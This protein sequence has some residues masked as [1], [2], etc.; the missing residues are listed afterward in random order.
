MGSSLTTSGV[1]RIHPL[2]TNW[3]LPIKRTTPS[4]QAKDIMRLTIRLK[5]L[6]AFAGVLALMALLGWTAV[7]RTSEMNADMQVFG[8]QTLPAA[9]AVGELKNQTGKFRRDQLRYATAPD[10]EARTGVAEDLTGDVD[11]VAGIVSTFEAKYLTSDQLRAALTAFNAGWEDYR[12]KSAELQPLTDAGRNAD[13]L[14]VINDG[15][16]DEAWDALKA[17][18]AALDEAGTAYA[19]EHVDEVAAD[20]AGA[21]RWTLTLLGLAIAMTALVAWLLTRS[22]SGGINRLLH[23]ARG[24]ADGDVDQNVTI[25]SKDE[26]GDAGREFERMIAYLQ[27]AAATADRI[28]DGDL[29]QP[30]TPHGEHDALGHALRRM[31]DNLRQTLGAVAGSATTVAS[32]S[33]QMAATSDETGRAVGEIAGAIANIAAGAERQVHSVERRARDDRRGRRR[34]GESAAAAQETAAAVNDAAA[35]AQEGVGA[36]EQATAAMHAVRESAT[37]AA[38]AIR[39]LG[40]KSEQIGGIVDTITGIAE[41]TNLLALNAAIEAARAGEQGRGFAVVAEEVRKL[42]EES[43]A[44]GGHDLRRSIE[45][46]QGETRTVVGVVEQASARTED[47]AATVEQAREAFLAIGHAVDGMTAR[48]DAIVGVADRIAADANAMEQGIGEV[49]LLAAGL[50]PRPSRSRRPPSRPRPRR[51]RSP[52]QRQSLS[53]TAKELEQIVGRFTL[54]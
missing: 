28:A 40:A 6:S 3:F 46:M 53:D 16:G 36:A 38:V 29:T 10:A 42:A 17:Q 31:S 18:I 50:A 22:L 5:L 51:R 49:S 35:V 14:A 9:R 27:E 19:T 21:K 8:S 30:V 24:I 23:A 41:Q 47:G 45:Q 34:L 33:Q 43:Q 39:D 13:A 2:R 32:A 48:V 15:A 12:A 1:N 11:T 44:R 7:T 52:P 4:D 54:A 37:E 20:A 25:N 26:L